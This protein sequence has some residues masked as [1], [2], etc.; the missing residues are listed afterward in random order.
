MSGWTAGG[1]E[2]LAEERGRTMLTTGRFE[3]RPAHR[4]IN[5]GLRGGAARPSTGYAFARIDREAREIADS[6]PVLGEDERPAPRAR[7]QFLDAVLLTLMREAPERSPQVFVTLF[8]TARTDRVLRLLDERA[9]WMDIFAIIWVLPWWI[10]LRA[11]WIYVRA[12]LVAI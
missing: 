7:D 4:V 1:F 9:T 3:R 11:W 5:I 6:L 10:F 8:A 12:R 2:V